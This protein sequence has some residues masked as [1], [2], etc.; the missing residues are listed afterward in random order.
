MA[1][2]SKLLNG[3]Q[4]V[5]PDPED[6]ITLLERSKKGDPAPFSLWRA[7]SSFRP[8]PL[9]S[10]THDP[11]DRRCKPQKVH[12]KCI[13]ISDCITSPKK[14][15]PG[16]LTRRRAVGFLLQGQ[17]LNLRPSGYEGDGRVTQREIRGIAN[18]CG[19]FAP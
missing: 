13:T 18:G 9:G 7:A 12:Q 17:D 16:R 10:A 2:V 8:G 11:E 15:A 6:F 19:E 1:E 4:E 5:A 14:P 3:T